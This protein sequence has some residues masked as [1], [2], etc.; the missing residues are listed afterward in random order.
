MQSSHSKCGTT[1]YTTVL[2]AYRPVQYPVLYQSALH[3][4][5]FK[6]VQAVSYLCSSL[7]H[8]VAHKTP[9]PAGQTT[10]YYRSLPSLVCKSTRRYKRVL[11][12]YDS[13]YCT[14]GLYKTLQPC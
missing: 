5:G 4:L 2:E 6:C 3:R 10:D 12:E 8:G 13:G 14:Q 9:L 7:Y 1:G 11:P